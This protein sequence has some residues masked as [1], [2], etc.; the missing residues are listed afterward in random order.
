MAYCEVL[1]S[2]NHDTTKKRRNNLNHEIVMFI[3]NSF[4]PLDTSKQMVTWCNDSWKERE[5]SKASHLWSSSRE[6]S[7]NLLVVGVV[8]NLVGKREEP[9]V[10]PPLVVA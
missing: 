1:S 6:A 9:R 3:Q 5:L 8:E 2:A 4:H 7:M 10:P